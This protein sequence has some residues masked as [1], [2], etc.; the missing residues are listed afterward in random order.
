[1]FCLIN[2]SLSKH[3]SKASIKRADKS[4]E[5]NLLKISTQLKGC[6][7]NFDGLID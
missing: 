4:I 7:I 5:E 1:M 3:Q 2:T 6:Y